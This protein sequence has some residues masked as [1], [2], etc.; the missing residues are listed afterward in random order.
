MN[1][2]STLSMTKRMP[3]GISPTKRRA[4]SRAAVVSFSG[5]WALAVSLVICLALF[6]L[7]RSVVAE[8]ESAVRVAE[9]SNQELLV[10]NKSLREEWIYLRSPEY[11]EP[12]AKHQLGLQRP[13][14]EQVVVI[15]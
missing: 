1:N 2:T 7:F 9:K 15:R 5:K 6:V 3:M 10:R 11:L 4:G 12:L 14:K 8:E 13:S